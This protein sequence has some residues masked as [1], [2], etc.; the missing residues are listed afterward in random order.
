MWVWV[1]VW[2]GVVA[3]G[4]V[5]LTNILLCLNHPSPVL[6]YPVTVYLPN[7]ILLYPAL[8]YRS[9]PYRTLG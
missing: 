7:P 5:Y 6:P 8:L 3:C 2:V 9:L 1:A 4:T